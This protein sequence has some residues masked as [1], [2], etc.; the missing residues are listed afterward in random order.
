M[1][2]KDLYGKLFNLFINGQ[3]ETGAECSEVAK[4]MGDASYLKL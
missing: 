2:P 4:F 1:S 3:T